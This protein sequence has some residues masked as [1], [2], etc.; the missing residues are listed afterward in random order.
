MNEERFAAE[1][2]KIQSVITKASQ[3]ASALSALADGAKMS[4]KKLQRT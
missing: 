2:K 4:R 1:T 3:K